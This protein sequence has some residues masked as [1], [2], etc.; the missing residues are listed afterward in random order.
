[1]RPVR[2]VLGLRWAW[3]GN[4]SVVLSLKERG[5]LPLRWWHHLGARMPRRWGCGSTGWARWERVWPRLGLPPSDR[6]PQ[7]L[8][9]LLGHFLGQCLPSAPRTG[10]GNFLCLSGQTFCSGF[11][12]WTGMGTGLGVWRH[13]PFLP[14]PST[15][16]QGRGCQWVTGSTV[17]LSGDPFW[18]GPGGRKRKRR[19]T[20]WER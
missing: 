11:R 14:P 7:A 19:S 5:V 12:T 13:F 9:T 18:D 8:P 1:M 15:P 6:N 20:S 3:A 2:S 17:T 10:F 4:G 16:S